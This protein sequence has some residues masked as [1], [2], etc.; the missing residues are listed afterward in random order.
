M[1]DILSSWATAAPP[2]MRSCGSPSGLSIGPDGDLYIADQANTR[3]R[4]VDAATGTIDT[5]A[6]GP[7]DGIPPQD[8]GDGG[9]ATSAEF[10]ILADVAVAA[11]GDF[12]IADTASANVRA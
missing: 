6:G 9:P 4:R 8:E 11:N 1:P 5:A 7:H 10:H 2:P 12:Y 3:I